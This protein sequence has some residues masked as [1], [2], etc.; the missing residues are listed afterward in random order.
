MLYL[1]ILA[2]LGVAALLCSPDA[3]AQPPT[4]RDLGERA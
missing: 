1:R 3:R 4:L 2:S